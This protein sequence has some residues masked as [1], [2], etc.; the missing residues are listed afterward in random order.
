[1]EQNFHNLNTEKFINIQESYKAPNRLDQKKT[2][3]PHNSQNT[4]H[5][6]ERKILE[7]SREKDK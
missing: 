5:T 2:Y 7:I 3:L 6:G 4:N 1:M